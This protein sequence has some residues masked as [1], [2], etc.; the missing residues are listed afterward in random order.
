VA[1]GDF[2]TRLLKRIEKIDRE[3]L[4]TYLQSVNRERDV[5]ERIFEAISEGIL[6]VSPEG[7]IRFMNQ[8]AKSLLGISHSVSMARKSLREVIQDEDFREFMEQH[9]SPHGHI[10]H[11]E[12][13]ILKPRHAF[14]S[15]SIAPLMDREENYQGAVVL[16][17]NTTFTGE[18]S[19]QVLASEKIESV[20]SLAAGVA[21]ELGNPLS[22]I[23]IHLRLLKEQFASLP[24][25]ARRKTE[26]CVDVIQAE[27]E[28]LDRMVK[29]FLRATRKRPSVFREEDVNA[30]VRD[31]AK[32]M[33]PE[34]GKAGIRCRLDLDKT[35]PPFLM[36]AERMH[37]LF[38]NL[39]KNAIESMPEG[40]SLEI[41][42]SRKDRLCT[43]VFR[44]EGMGISAEHLPHVFE[45]YYTTKEEG[46]GLGLMIAYHVVKDHG[47]KIEVKSRW[48]EGTS[49]FI[50]LPIRREKLE[51]PEGLSNSA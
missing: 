2:L 37:Q 15:V 36:D 10:V 35:V 12:L 16:L 13:E 44:D 45:A 47:G 51:L 21:H 14:V 22:S 32:F 9:I 39:M 11:H 41:S 30:L 3:S 25:T 49:F 33:G 31:A 50:Y 19:R 28:R 48:G 26:E 8:S 17:I 5:Y 42:S 38:I 6:V 20:I 40:G 1:E 34:M 18:R 24:L 29:N 27:T 7:K 23:M 4:Q 46:S 43:L